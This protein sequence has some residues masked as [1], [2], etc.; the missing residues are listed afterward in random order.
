MS[1][2]IVVWILTAL[3]AVRIH[4]TIGNDIRGILP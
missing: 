3:A 1:F 2:P 4:T